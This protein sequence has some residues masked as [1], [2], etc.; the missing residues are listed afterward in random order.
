MKEIFAL[1][2]TVS[3]IQAIEQ[4]KPPASFLADTFFP[5]KM[6]TAMTSYV[7]VEY[8]KEGRLLAPYV[9]KGSRG[10]NINRS[11][12]KVNMYAPPMVAPRRV[13]SPEDVE[14]RAFGETPVF[15]TVTPAQRAAQMQ[16]NDLVELQ[17]MIVN[18]KNKMA[19]D[20]LTNGATTIKGYAD[21]GQVVIEDEIKFDW[22]GK[23]TIT[24]D[25]DQAGATI[26][27]DIKNASE[28]IEE[29]TGVTPTV[30]I[31]G[32]NIEKY[33]LD[34][35]EIFKWLNVPN[36]QNFSLM[37]IQ[38]RIVSPQ[39]RRIGIIQSLNLEIYSYA[40]T[41]TDDDGQ[42]KNFLDPDTVIIGIPGRGKE[43][44]GAITLLQQGAGNYQTYAA[45]LVPVY[46]ADYLSQQ[47]TLTLYSRFLL[48]PSVIDDFCSI[49]VKS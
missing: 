12:S 26:Y 15:S 6:P 41:Y 21:D 43:L 48:V 49:K 9:V 3:L 16:A 37:S 18:R 31:C 33:I 13:I 42:V 29:D 40:E 38:P 45:P 1:K 10:V 25:W 44:T 47:L 2:D 27:A 17:R 35:T 39:V 46:T 30:M 19:A 36:A 14:L 23:I 8:K 4:I 28:K 24:T 20:I 5:N 11:T 32:K 22:N 34:N 7:A